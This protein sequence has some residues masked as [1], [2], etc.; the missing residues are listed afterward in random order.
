VLKQLASIALLLIVAAAVS[1]AQQTPLSPQV[2]VIRAGR[3]VDVDAGRVL[4]SQMLLLRGGKIEAMGENLSVPAGATV[5]DLSKMTV[6]P[7]LLD[8]HT[9]LADLGDAEPLL[10]LQKSAVESAYAVIP[11]A[12]VTL[13]A[14]F[15]TVRDVGVYRAFNDVALR[16]ACGDRPQRGQERLLVVDNEHTD[17]VHG[18]HC[19][20][21]RAAGEAGHPTPPGSAGTPSFPLR[22][23]P[24][25]PWLSA[26]PG[27]ARA[28]AFRS[29]GGRS[30]PG[31]PLR[32]SRR[33]G[34]R[35][36]L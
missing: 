14:G 34:R 36:P 33:R 18:L 5:I 23:G 9:H 25:G 10:V 28:L 1:L 11:N 22:R 3:L 6:L 2:T 7:G 16:D 24:L 15:T 26:P 27:A 20:V 29:A 30:G 32:L 8:C 35:A 31:F 13:L 4:T 19:R 21:R 17:G 12:R